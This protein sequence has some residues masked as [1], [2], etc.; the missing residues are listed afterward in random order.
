MNKLAKRA[1]SRNY[2]NRINSA[3][4]HQWVTVV[5]PYNRR[6][7]LQACDDCGVVKSENSMI[8]RCTAGKGVGI[9]SRAMQACTQIAV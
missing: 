3:V 1:Y 7:L 8:K 2:F 6:S 9:I 5:N 4:S